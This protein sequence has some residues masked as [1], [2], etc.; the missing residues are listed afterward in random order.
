MKNTYWLF[1]IF[2]F[3]ALSPSLYAQWYFET[4]LS[5]TDF[6]NYSVT[7]DNG[8]ADIHTRFVPHEGLRDIG[9]ELGYLFSFSKKD[10]LTANARP[11]FFR[12]GLGLGFEQM[13]IRTN[14]YF[15]QAPSPTNVNYY[16]AQ[17][18]AK[19]S[20][21]LTPLVIYNKEEAVDK[22]PLFAF[23]VHGGAGYNQFTSAIVH[24]S[25][26]SVDLL[27]TGSDFTPNYIS[28]HYGAGVQ[29][30]LNKN[31]QFYLRQSII[32]SQNIDETTIT[33]DV[34]TK[35]AY[36]YK[37]NRVAL[38]LLFDVAASNKHKKRQYD[39]MN[40]IKAQMNDTTKL[41]AS[42][43][44]LNNKNA[45]VAKQLDDLTAQMAQLKTGMTSLDNIDDQSLKT[46]I[47]RSGVGYFPEFT[48]VNFAVGSANFD[49]VTY[50]EL[51]T[52]M[53]KLLQDNP[54]LSVRLVGY[55]DES[56]DAAFNLELS[57]NRAFAVRNYLVNE[58]GISQDRIFCGAAGETKH[59]SITNPKHNRRTE[60][61][62]L[63]Y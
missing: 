1:L 49:Q 59:F 60:I 58:H 37:R 62:I 8:N 15:N 34:I 61:A 35:R 14:A 30:F 39:T 40:A 23:N 10:T 16:M 27:A 31:T 44:T 45:Q 24:K 3:F 38:G 12:L 46:S 7:Q 22:Q 6:D 19:A 48:H 55:A 21:L 36:N 25:I 18:Q 42:L 13:N 54:K 41:L 32:T 50:K 20:I 29:F 52:K 57:K 53:A 33:S 26:S 28:L 9:Y 4:G 11:D 56:G 43:D 47:H 5:T 2:S 51:F 63:H 17:L